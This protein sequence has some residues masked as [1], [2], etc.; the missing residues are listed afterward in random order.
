MVW[1]S[2]SL[3]LLG[4]ASLLVA[5][6]PA[7]TEKITYLTCQFSNSP[8]EI[9]LDEENGRA[10]VLVVANGN[11]FTFAAHYSPTEISFGNSLVAYSL[12]RL[13]G[14]ATRKSKYLSPDYANCVVEKVPERAF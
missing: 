12:D 6:A 3:T 1:S 10:S 5:A 8:I 9:T 4:L 2:R 14:V 13:T 7:P 11:T